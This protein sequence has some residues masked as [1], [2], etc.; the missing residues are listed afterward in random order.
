MIAAVFADYASFFKFAALIVAA[1]VSACNG[2]ENSCSLPDTSTPGVAVGENVASVVTSPPADTV[3]V[4]TSNIQNAWG[5]PLDSAMVTYGPTTGINQD[6]GPYATKTGTD[7][8]FANRKDPVVAPLDMKF[9]GFSNRSALTRSDE[10]KSPYDDLEVC[11]E[12]V[13]PNWPGMKICVYHLY[14][15]P[16]LTKHSETS[17]SCGFQADWGDRTQAGGMMYFEYNDTNYC[18]DSAAVS[19]CG[20]L[21]GKIL[22]RGSVIGYAGQ[23][24]PPSEFSP[25]APIRLKVRTPMVNPLVTSGDKYLQWVQGSVFFYWKELGS[26]DPAS[27]GVLTFTRDFSSVITG[28][29]ADSSFKYDSV[30]P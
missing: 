14:T 26:A 22:T 20:A 27:P 17:T 10:G 5:E 13:D 9:I 1:S 8:V 16:L 6:E 7:V 2:G 21:L 30:G 18:V 29:E 15:S 3:G 25:F 24:G 23:V 4:D 28:P 19:E 11:F 12:S